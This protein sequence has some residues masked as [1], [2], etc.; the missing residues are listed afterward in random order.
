M[1][2][3]Q[4]SAQNPHKRSKASLIILIML[5]FLLLIAAV[6]MA[7]SIPEETVLPDTTVPA[8]T[9]AA[10]N[11]GFTCDSVEAQKLFPFGQGVVKLTNNRLAYLTIEGTEV[12]AEEIDMAS[13]Y[14]V[15]SGK[16]LIACDREGT[17]YVVINEEGVLFKGNR[18]G[19]LVGASF[20]ADQTLALIEDRHNSTGVVAILD[21]LT[22]QL[23]YECFFPESGYVLSV[24]FTPDNKAFDVVL[25]NTDG[26]KAEPLLKR[27]SITGEPS[28]QRILD[29]EGIYPLVIYDSAGQPVLCSDT[30]L[31]GVNYE[32]DDYRFVVD[33]PRIEAV[34]ETSAEPVVLAGE[35]LGGKLGIYS[36][37]TAGKLSSPLDVGDQVTAMTV[38]G[39]YVA[40]GSGTHVYVYDAKSRQMILDSNLA[41]EIVRVDFV[42]DHLLT[43]VT[44]TG[45]LRLTVEHP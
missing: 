37:D 2:T 17:S 12:F 6:M 41:A 22:G 14:V 8:E 25:V 39:Q 20:A 21:A 3:H 5:A 18:E 19:R 26:A 35:R 29:V 28:G 27:F 9:A 40:F 4:R 44:G 1:V 16:R 45:V 11:L 10:S 24:R 32:Q 43:V 23:K 15:L 13:P 34:A 30:Q 33:L 36:L 7:M 31:V 38:S 42:D